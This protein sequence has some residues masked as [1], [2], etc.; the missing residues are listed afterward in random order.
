MGVTSGRVNTN[1]ISKTT[2]Y[3][4]WQQTGQST[5]NN[6]T[7]IDWQAGINTGTSTSHDDYYN[8]AVKINEIYIN[9][10]KVYAGGTW[11]QIHVGNDKQLTSGTATIPHNSDGSK[12]FEI[13][14][15]AWTYSSSNYSGSDT[16]TLNNIPRQATINSAT[17]FNDEGNPTITYTNSAGNSVTTLQA[18]IALTESSA[19]SNPIIS[20]RDISKTGSSYTF[21]LTTAEREALRNAMPT[22]TTRNLWFFVKTILGGVTYYSYKIASIT[23]VNANP[24]IDTIDYSDINQDTYDFTGDYHVI[25]QGLSRLQFQMW[26]VEA[27]KGATLSTLSI[28]I[29]GNIVTTPF[30]GTSIISTTYTYGEVDVSEN[31]TAILTLTDSRG[32]SSSYN[33]P[34]TIWEYENPT[35]IITEYR[36]SNFYTESHIKVD[37]RYSSLNN[38]NTITIKYRIKKSIESTWGAWTTISDNVEADFNADNQYAWDI[39]V[40]LED[41]VGGYQLYTINKALDVGIP[42]VFYDVIMRSVGINNLP[43]HGTSFEVD[44]NLYVNGENVK[45]RHIITASISSNITLNVHTNYDITNLSLVNQVGSKLTLSSTGITIGAGVS[46]ILVS[47][48]GNYSTIVNSTYSRYLKVKVNNTE[49]AAV[50]T[51]LNGATSGLSLAITPR[52]IDVQQGDVIGFAIQGAENDVF[53][54]VEAFTSFYVEVVE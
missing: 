2:F 17:D 4:T 3:V 20:W 7:T 31:T 25:I 10:V 52:L 14:I 43:T 39:Q 21:E 9:G 47:A 18:C 32:N 33:V 30:T 11:S 22:Q 40:E 1:K 54:G 36:E 34:L 5:E 45:Q 12:S 44:G 16:F 46:K 29:N 35:A 15:K 53:R 26:D 6:Q 49:V 42:I 38:L 48:N 50:R 24:F 23:I 19:Q 8:N 41:A 28:N 37:A 27:F 51:G 13:S